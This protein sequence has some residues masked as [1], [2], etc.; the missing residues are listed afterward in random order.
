AVTYEAYMSCIHAEDQ[1]WVAASIE[2][3]LAT[4]E[5]YEHEYRIVRPDGEERWVHARVAV[6]TARDGV[7]E[8]LAGYCQDVTER[9][10]AE[11]ARRPVDRVVRRARQGPRC[12]R[13]VVA[14]T[15]RERRQGDRHVRHVPAIAA[16]AGRVRDPDGD[17]LG[18]LCRARARTGTNGG[19]AHGGGQRGS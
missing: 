8:R 17:D 14:A 18:E 15:L 19:G 9:R 4:S 1:Q 13:R 12:A 2:E 11:D 10:V 7:P 16:L 3:I 6:V 5:P